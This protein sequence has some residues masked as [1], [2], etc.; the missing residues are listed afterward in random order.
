MP[1][2]E[3]EETAAF[4]SSGVAP[5]GKLL[6]KAEFIILLE[7][8]IRDIAEDDSMEGSLSYEWGEE[9]ESFRVQAALRVGNSAGQGGLR[10]IREGI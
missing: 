7:A 8:L 10:L 2:A 1:G 9:P 3:E 5:E 4:E 6:T